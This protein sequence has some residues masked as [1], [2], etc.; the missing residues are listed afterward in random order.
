MKSRSFLPRLKPV[1]VVVM[2]AGF[3]LIGASQKPKN[4]N[5]KYSVTKSSVDKTE[6]PSPPPQQIN[7]NP[8]GKSGALDKI[9]LDNLKAEKFRTKDGKQAWKVTIPGNRPLATPAV[10]DG[11]VYVGG[12]FGSYE[13]YA[14]DAKDGRPVWAIRVNDDGPTAAV[15]DKGVVAFNTESCTLFVV[16][17]KTG[18]MLW[19]KWLGDPLMSQPAIADDKI[20]MAFPGNG[21]HELIALGLRDGKEHWRAGIAGDII[22]APVVYKGSVYLSTFDGTVYRYD[23]KDGD[24][25]WKKDFQATSAPWLYQDQVFVSKRGADDKKNPTEGVARMEKDKGEQN[26]KQG[27]WNKK[28]APYLDAKVQQSSEYRAKQKGL[29][30]SV[31][32]GSAP[33]TAKVA[34]A[35]ANVGQGT[36]HG[37]WEFQGSRPCVVNGKL[38]L[39]QGDQVVALDP[40]SG[41]ELWSKDIA[42]DLKRIGGHLAAPPSPAGKNLYVATSTGEIMVLSQARGKTEDVI[43]IGSTMRFQPSLAKGMLYVGTADG[44]LIGI[45]LEDK[46][47]DGWYMWGGGPTHNGV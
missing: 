4:L 1:L 10:A 22:S 25:V 6:E 40:D 37:L 35:E 39:T 23:L 34:A 32:F 12:G 44:Q 2:L 13:F 9:P 28:A 33:G 15:V 5:E 31:G 20:L 27:M 7:Q 24:L 43:K 45:D 26:Q 14:F 42:G 18:R 36:V 3:G 8:K 17:G 46:T 11:M 47:A 38:F 29:D 41:K 21:G 16:D 30:S 19:S